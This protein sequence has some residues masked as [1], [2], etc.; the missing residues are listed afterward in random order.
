MPLRTA[1]LV[2][3][4]DE[5]HRI[6]RLLQGA[7]GGQSG[8]LVVRGEAGIGKS[9]LLEY[10]IASASGFQVVRATGVE[11][12]MELAFAGLHQLCTPLLEALLL[13]P[14]PRGSP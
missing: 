11:S 1:D 5:C 8:V 9:A 7:R 13:L 6:D 2:G 3:R 4:A 14:E 12:E 10:A